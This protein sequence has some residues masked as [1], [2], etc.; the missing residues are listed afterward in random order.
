VIKLINF[1]YV[2]SIKFLIIFKKLMNIKDQFT[3][4]R[5]IHNRYTIYNIIYLI[6]ILYNV[7][8][9]IILIYNSRN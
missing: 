4:K 1:T 5:E 7:I 6:N 3:A 2:L 8:F 9:K